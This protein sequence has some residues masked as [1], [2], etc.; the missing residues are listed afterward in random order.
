MLGVGL[1]RPLA[2]AS[3]ANPFHVG[4]LGIHL[5]QEI[6]VLCRFL[7]DLR[8]V[9]DFVLRRPLWRNDAPFQGI[10]EIDTLFS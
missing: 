2:I 8:P 3:R 10:N 1:F 7:K 9:I 4:A 5:F 6:G